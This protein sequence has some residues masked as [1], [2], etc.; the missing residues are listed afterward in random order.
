MA[1]SQAL[2]VAG[3][4]RREARLLRLVQHLA[5]AFHGLVHGIVPALMAMQELVNAVPNAGR[6]VNAVLLLEGEV[7]GEVQKGVDLP[8]FNREISLEHLIGIIEK[9]VVLGVKGDPVGRQVLNRRQWQA[10]AMPLPGSNEKVSNLFS[11]GLKNHGSG[12]QAIVS[13]R[14]SR[15]GPRLAEVFNV[16]SP[17]LR[18]A[19]LAGVSAVEN[20]PMM[21]TLSKARGHVPLEGLLDG[22]NSPARGEPHAV[23]DPKNMGVNRKGLPAKCGVED[24]IG[25][26][27]THPRQGLQGLAILWHK[28]I[29]LIEKARAGLNHMLGLGAIEADRLDEWDEA[30]YPKTQDARGRVGHWEEPGRGLIDRF[31]GGLGREH[32]CNEQLKWPLKLELCL[33]L[34]IV[35]GQS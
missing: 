34:W 11:R 13:N 10:L 15:L 4:I 31:I 27:A 30:V 21:G 1:G 8:I 9:V 14:G 33:G 16:A 17:A 23:R 18:L 6:L 28:A 19:G 35:S 24:N 2:K 20:Q 7:H 25:S 12:R 26:L 5:Q 22:E 32:H 29:V 3:G